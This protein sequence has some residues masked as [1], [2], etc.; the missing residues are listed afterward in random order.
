MLLRHVIM[1]LPFL[2]SFYIKDVVFSNSATGYQDWLATNFVLLRWSD[3]V[4][5]WAADPIFNHIQ[6]Q[7]GSWNKRNVME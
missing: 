3:A 4:Y 5:L 7:I 6:P 2:S 1:Q